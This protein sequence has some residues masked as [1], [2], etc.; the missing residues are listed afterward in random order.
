[1][2][3]GTPEASGGKQSIQD[4]LVSQPDTSINR[5]WFPLYGKLKVETKESKIKDHR[6]QAGGGFTEG[7]GAK[8]LGGKGG[9]RGRK[10]NYLC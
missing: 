8:K 6:N 10:K 1:M 3:G 4:L 7:E 2:K 5:A 9:Q